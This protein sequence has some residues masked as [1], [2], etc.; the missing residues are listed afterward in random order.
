MSDAQVRFID[1]FAGIG[2]MRIPFE[3]L[4]CKCVFSCD[5]DKDAQKTYEA[6][7]GER[8]AGDITKIDACDIPDHEVLLGGFPCQAFSIIGKMNGFQDTRGT[9]FFDIE[10]ILKE[11]RPPA[12]LLENVKMLVNH[13]KGRTF[14]VILDHLRALDYFVHWR[15]LNALDFGV[16]HKRE[17]VFIVG[18]LENY[19]FQFPRGNPGKYKSL[20]EILE[21]RVPEKYFASNSIV[22]KRKRDHTPEITP[23]IWH[24]NK[25]GNIASHP[26][27]CALRSGA[28]YNYLL[29][30]GERRLT[31]RECLRLLGFPEWY[32]IDGTISAMRKLTGNSVCVP[33]VKAIALR[34]L[35]CLNEQIPMRNTVAMEMG[36][37]VQL[38][39]PV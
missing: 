23:S 9:L 14:R 1:L 5:W 27:S 2:G 37:A 13:Q 39:L 20:T 19:D 30:N 22:M 32:R 18:F 6:N 17:R 10:R 34:I 12:F 3:E 36:K 8:P 31:P 15:V 24:E 11:K 35:K 33:V 28:S 38:D 7:F 16:P 25:G 4:G 26:F 21:K 29:V